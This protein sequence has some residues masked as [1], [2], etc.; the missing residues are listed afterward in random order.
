MVTVETNT[1]SLEVYIL[2][3]RYHSQL[4]ARVISKIVTE[5]WTCLWHKYLP[6]IEN[7]KRVWAEQLHERALSPVDLRRWVLRTNHTKIWYIAY[8]LLIHSWTHTLLMP[9]DGTRHWSLSKQDKDKLWNKLFKILF[10]LIFVRLKPSH[11]LGGFFIAHEIANIFTA[12]VV[13]EDVCTSTKGT[14]RWV[15]DNVWEM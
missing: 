8:R 2:N 9:V 6:S 13:G 11:S 3:E 5:L 15:R 10:N 14:R 12:S 4:Q 1:R 7:C